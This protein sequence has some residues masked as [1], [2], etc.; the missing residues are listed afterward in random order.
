MGELTLRNWSPNSHPKENEP[1]DKEVQ[2]QINRSIM[3][4]ARMAVAQSQPGPLPSFS[5]GSEFGS[6]SQSQSQSQ[7]MEIYDI[8][9]DDEEEDPCLTQKSISQEG[10]LLSD[11]NINENEKL[12]QDVQKLKSMEISQPQDPRARNGKRRRCEQNVLQ[13]GDGRGR[14][15]WLFAPV[16]YAQHWWL[17]VLDVKKRKFY[18]LDSLN[19]T[20]PG[21]DRNK[22]NRFASNVLDQIQYMEV[23][24][25]SFLEKRNFTVPIWTEDELQQFREEF[26]ERILFNGDNFF[27]QQ[28][29][30]VSNPVARHQRPSAALQSPYVQLKSMDSESGKLG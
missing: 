20:A 8:D 2:E 27:R 29:L 7:P 4:V 5:L 12:H 13:M 6:Q 23:V 18:A 10:P 17:Y 14:K 21:R 9:D 16:L 22:L 11:K 15:Q 25:P 1:S 28:A 24:N 19:S 3:M 26:V 30:K